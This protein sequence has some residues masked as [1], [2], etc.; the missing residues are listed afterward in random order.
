M[1]EQSLSGAASNRA[2]RRKRLSAFLVD[3]ICAAIFFCVCYLVL[4]LLAQMLFTDKALCS[5]DK[6]GIITIDFISTYMM[7]KLVLSPDSH[8]LYDMST[9]LL[10]FNKVIYPAT[11]KVHNYCQY[12]PFYPLLFIPLTLLTLRQALLAWDGIALALGSAGLYLA[13]RN[14]RGLSRVSVAILVLGII[15]SFPTGLAMVNGEMTWLFLALFC[16]FYVGL[17]KKRDLIA[18]VAL[19]VA[20]IKPHFF[21]FLLIPALVAWR[22]R[23]L[24]TAAAT[25]AVLLS[26]AG[27][28]VGWENV[29]GYPQVLLHAEKFD[30]AVF[31][32]RMVCLRGPAS[33]FLPKTAALAV[34]FL[35][36]IFG[37]ALT[38]WFWF[39]TLRQRKMT[40]QWAMA[41]SVLWLLITSPHLHV[42]DCVLI[43]LPA[44][45]TLSTVRP[46]VLAS[47]GP[48]SL[49][50]W[51]LILC[52]YPLASWL[53]MQASKL[54]QVVLPAT[55]LD[56]TVLNGTP[57]GLLDYYSY[58]CCH[59]LAAA[60]GTWYAIKYGAREL[61]AQSAEEAATGSS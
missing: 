44:A 4:N 3:S 60:A 19:G 6:N 40:A 49:R 54:A 55:L 8:K 39:R 34:G 13:S 24:L 10:W 30:I 22:V 52:F 1:A 28:V 23:L 32:E 18:G 5:T 31:P 9:Q 33:A 51:C 25:V 12:P 46:S 57:G 50:I 61:P 37:S 41:L 48:L 29:F 42:Y 36:W 16:V 21:I 59:I 58:L 38:A 14:G 20:S 7:S 26:L 15:A 56:M 45:L 2:A 35:G 47:S 53:F 11:A 27:V 43:A 17:I